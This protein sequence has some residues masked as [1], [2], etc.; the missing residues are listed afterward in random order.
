MVGGES[1]AFDAVRPAL[2]CVGRT[3]VHQGGPG[4]GQHTKVVNQTLIAANMVGV[5]EALLY[6]RRAGLDPERVLASVASGAAGSWSLQ[7]LAPRILARRLRAGLLRRALRQGHADHP[8][9]SEKMGLSLPGLALAKRLYEKLV[10]LGH[11]RSGTQALILALED[12][13]I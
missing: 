4:A 3:L 1:A 12:E 2:A 6:A 5:C 7:N 8:E 10:R 13:E 11:G 9:E